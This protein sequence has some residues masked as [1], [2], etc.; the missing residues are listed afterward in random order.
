MYGSIVFH[1]SGEQESQLGLL[2]DGK[3]KQK[4]HQERGAMMR[5]SLDM[6][7]HGVSWLCSVIILNFSLFEAFVSLFLYTYC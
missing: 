7:W 5:P 2:K 4:S 3:Q 1:T 6:G